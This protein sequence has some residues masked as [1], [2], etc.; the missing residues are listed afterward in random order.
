MSLG[1]TEADKALKYV[2]KT[3]NYLDDLISNK[4]TTL[5]LIKKIENHSG[6]GTPIVP[7]YGLPGAVDNDFATAQTAADS[8]SSAWGEFMI[9]GFTKHADAKISGDAIARAR[10]QDGGW[11][12]PIKDEVDGTMNSLANRRAI[13]FFTAGWGEIGVIEA[14]SVSGATLRLTLKSAMQRVEKDQRHVF[15]SGLSSG[16]LAG[17]GASLKVVSVDRASRQITYNANISTVSSGI[18]D[19]Y[20]V[21][22]ANDREN[23]ASPSRKVMSG[24]EAWCPP[25]GY[26][27]S[28]DSFLGQ[29]RSVDVTRLAG[30]RLDATGGASLEEI[31]QEAAATVCTDGDLAEFIVSPNTFRALSV[32]LGTRTRF[33]PVSNGRVGFSSI[34][35]SGPNGD[36]SVL[37]DRFH[38][39]DRIY[40][41]N[42]KSWRVYSDGKLVRLNDDDGMRVLRE[43]AGDN[44]EAR[45]VSRIAEYVCLAP[46]NNINIK[47]DVL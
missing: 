43:G 42:L 40:G 18:T 7:R 31:L 47:I 14:G 8:T 28:G 22:F 41:T 38:S 37:S 5:A 4:R 36:I 34:T 30:H 12:K 39:D 45:I 10:N 33:Q 26:S 24:F 23:S 44:V 6:K 9:Y 19:G 21:F 32:Q 1:V 13:D 15:G 2:Y 3:E 25:H 16:V 46:Q 35:I 29:D 20:Y 11:L 17:S 27:F